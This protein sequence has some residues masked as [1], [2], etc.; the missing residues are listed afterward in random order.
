MTSFAESQDLY[1]TELV[2]GGENALVTLYE[3]GSL[4][5]HVCA[6]FATE[7]K[8]KLRKKFKNKLQII[9]RPF[10]FNKIDV[11]GFK[12][13]FCSTDAVTYA[14]TLFEKQDEWISAK[15]Q[16][17]AIMDLVN[18]LGMTEGEIKKC[19]ANKQL[20]QQI[21]ARRQFIK[22]D[23][24][25]ILKIGKVKIT[26]LPKYEIL[27][28]WVDEAIK[29]VADGNNLSEFQ[30]SSDLRKSMGLKPLENDTK[31]K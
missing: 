8:D 7:T 13:V 11:E 21:I 19:L 20:E 17:K 6:K 18:S 26:G 28:Q 5:C 3:Y 23:A 22:A 25:P 12:L 16:I 10:P 4:T 14:T 24:A 30:G 29:F 2:V 27:E 1:T 31:T 9:M 15:N